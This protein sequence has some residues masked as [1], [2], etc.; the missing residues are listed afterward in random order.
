MFTSLIFSF[1][2]SVIPGCVLT[3]FIVS[4]ARY[5]T[6]KHKNKQSPD[7]YA[8]E[9]IRRRLIMLIVSSIMLG[10]LVAVVIGFIA[11]MFMAVAF[12]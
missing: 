11:L 9:D 6:A 4:L 7:T 3:F 12:M 1:L 5:L 2:F 10:I 8:P